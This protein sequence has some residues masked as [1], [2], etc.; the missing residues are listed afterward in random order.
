MALQTCYI[1][2]QTPM[3]AKQG[4]ISLHAVDG[5]TVEGELCILGKTSPIQGTISEYGACR[6]TGELI[7]LMRVF[8]FEAEGCLNGESISLTFQSGRHS[9]ALVGTFLKEQDSL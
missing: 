5:G 8:P 3:G 9:F 2:L 4:I 1:A 6:L 7:S